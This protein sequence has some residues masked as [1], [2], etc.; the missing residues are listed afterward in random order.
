MEKTVEVTSIPFTDKEYVKALE[1]LLNQS[2]NIMSIT[3]DEY[4]NKELCELNKV[5]NT[6]FEELNDA[7]KIK[8]QIWLDK[9]MKENEPD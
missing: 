9:K 3:D 5:S 2:I 6:L 7:N 8:F 4:R 1:T